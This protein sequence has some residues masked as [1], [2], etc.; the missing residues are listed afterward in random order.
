MLETDDNGERR[1][2]KQERGNSLFLVDFE[3][4]LTIPERKEDRLRVLICDKEIAAHWARYVH[5]N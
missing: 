5:V 2:G 1:E 3:L 4:L